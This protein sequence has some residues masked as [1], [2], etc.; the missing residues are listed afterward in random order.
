M[1]CVYILGT[2]FFI[3]MNLEPNL[4]AVRINHLDTVS[5]KNVFFET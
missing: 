1:G 3:S 5:D 4:F 2:S